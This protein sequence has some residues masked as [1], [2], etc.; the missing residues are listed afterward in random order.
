VGSV[1]DYKGNVKYFTSRLTL[2]ELCKYM[3]Y[4]LDF[5]TKWPRIHLHVMEADI[6]R[7]TTQDYKVEINKI[8]NSTMIKRLNHEDYP[9]LHSYSDKS[10]SL[11]YN[12]KPLII[13]EDKPS[14][15]H[16]EDKP[17]NSK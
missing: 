4:T 14:Y 6:I 16:F 5:A 15:A 9:S 10:S 1:K 7:V 11:I 17:L 12:Y 13:Y 8:K 2:K 3:S